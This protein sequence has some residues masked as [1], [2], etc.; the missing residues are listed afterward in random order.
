MRFVDRFVSQSELVEYIA[1]ADI[2][3]TPYLNAQ[4]STSGT[5]AYAVGCGKAVVST[6]YQYAQELLSDGRGLLVSARD[7]AA[8]ATAVVGLFDAPEECSAMK[9]RAAAYG[10]RMGWPAVARRYLETLNSASRT[11]ELRPA[12][13]SIRVGRLS[14]TSLPRL[15]LTH[16]R[17][18]TDDTGLLQHATFNIPCYSEGYCLD[19]NARALLLMVQLEADERLFPQLTRTLAARYLAFVQHAFDAQ[20]G[21]FRNFL[22]YSRTWAAGPGSDDSH[23]RALWALGAVVGRSVD[24]GHVGLAQRLF[25]AALPAASKATSPRAWAYTLLGLDE[26]SRRLPRDARVEAV[27]SDLAGRLVARFSETATDAWPWFEDRLTYCNA[28]LAQALLVSASHLQDDHM[29][30][31]GLRALEWLVAQHVGPAGEFAPVGTNG[32]FVRA[33]VRAQYDQQPVEASCMVSACLSAAAAVERAP[34]SGGRDVFLAAP[35]PVGASLGHSRPEHWR[36]IAV[37]AFEW[38]L[39]GNSRRQGLY[40]RTTGGCRDGIH[41]D[42]LNENQ[43]A[44]STLAFLMALTEMQGVVSARAGVSPSSARPQTPTRQLANVALHA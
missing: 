29:R 27:R 38:F 18:M 43:G 11:A 24:P 28:R 25:H 21:H 42:R 14:D 6:P 41:I 20:T 10:A 31:I 22:S 23:G 3:T 26:L 36:E 35:G 33:E 37:R 7:G 2:Y 19:D 15:D 40:D 12:G 44:E 9:A 8:I 30:G 4:Q 34:K 17:A 1:V 5:L 32:F 16:L 13:P 39:G